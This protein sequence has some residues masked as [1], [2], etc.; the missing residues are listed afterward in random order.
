MRLLIVVLLTG[1]AF[2]A[3]AFARDGAP[4]VL[5]P[6]ELNASSASPEGRVRVRGV[7]QLALTDG[8]YLHQD[9]RAYGATRDQERYVTVLRSDKVAW[10]A[11]LYE[12]ALVVV[13]GNYRKSGCRAPGAACPHL[14]NE[15]DPVSIEVLG[16][17]DK[18][19]AE[20]KS[21]DGKRPLRAVHSGDPEWVAVAGLVDR[22]R[23]AVRAR[24]V[25]ALSAMIEPRVEAFARD[26]DRRAAI[27]GAFAPGARAQWRLFDP[28]SA[29]ID[30]RRP[31][32]AYRVYESPSWPSYVS[33]S[34]TVCFDKGVRSQADWP[35]SVFDLASANL[36][37][38]FACIV[39][40]RA[41]RGWWLEI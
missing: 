5:A 17:P 37:D 23:R 39:A 1:L 38:P 31:E 28:A 34:L 41:D 16:Y 25:K 10:Y 13:T 14:K 22:F 20:R 32:P 33:R 30:E 15:L 29:F 21:D 27:D 18:S 26:P 24:D 19:A 2:A 12:A 40:V 4:P 3:C 36:G 11:E 8:P 6:Q 35:D 7:L 9:M